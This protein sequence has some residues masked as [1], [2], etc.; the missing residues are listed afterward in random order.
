MRPQSF[1]KIFFPATTEAILV[2]GGNRKLSKILSDVEIVS[3]DGNEECR[4]PRPLPKGIYGMV[5]YFDGDGNK[6]IVCG[7]AEEG[8]EPLDTCF[9]YSLETD[10]WNE[11]RFGMKGKREMAESV[12]LNNGSF[13]VLGG[14]PS[15]E[16]SEYP[17]EGK[18]GPR[19]PNGTYAQCLSQINQT[20]LFMAGRLL[21]ANTHAYLLALDKG[22][23][24]QLP[25]MIE[26]R[27][28]HICHPIKGGREVLAIGGWD[29][30]SVESFSFDSMSWRSVNPLPR[31]IENARYAVEYKET[32]LIVGGWDFNSRPRFLDTLYEFVPS[33]Y[34]WIERSEKLKQRRAN[35]LSLPLKSGWKEK[36]KVCN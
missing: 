27:F 4:K 28:G 8:W 25:D 13:L 35:H 12:L 31:K 7:G 23:W 1:K 10:E 20:H 3:L 26:E 5:G 14:K 22:E 9:E 2:I 18:Q 15:F 16:T 29:K 32:F 30:S 17:I 24:I 33:D 36:A 11:A 6:A 34:T 19:L 21:G